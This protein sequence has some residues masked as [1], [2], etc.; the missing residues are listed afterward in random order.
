MHYIYLAIDLGTIAFPLVFSFMRPFYF[1]KQWAYFF[2]A[3]LMV[4]LLYI[5][6]DAGFTHMG[7]WGFS[8][9]YTLGLYVL[10][11]PFEEVL[12]FICI[13][14]ACTFTFYCF[15]IVFKEKDVYIKVERVLTPLLITGFAIVAITNY[16]RLYTLTAFG[17]T[18]II[19][20]CAKYILKVR[21]LW[22]FYAVYIVIQLPFFVVNG[23]LTGHWLKG[24]VV[25][26]NN[27]QNLA[28]RLTTIP[29]EDV[30]YGMGLLLL[31]AVVFQYVRKKFNSPSLLFKQ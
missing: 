16:S 12:F 6:W 4:T 7:I 8:R 29:V 11:L 5:I 19:M 14:Y 28:V 26:Y 25:W 31:N 10:N 21:W 23:L 24:P 9:Q 15:S 18:A 3:V 2:P 13:P 22:L 20:A 27:N 30:F 17:F 1:Y